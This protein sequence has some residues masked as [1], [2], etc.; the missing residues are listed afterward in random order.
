MDKLFAQQL[1]RATRADGEIDLAVLEELVVAAYAQ[2]ER[3]R[4]LIDRSTALMAEE[5]EQLNRGLERVVEERTAAL[6]DREA[7]LAGQNMLIDTAINNMPQGLV[8]FDADA[9]VVICNKRYL[10]MSG[11]RQD[12]VQPGQPLIELLRYRTAIGTFSGDPEQYIR[13]LLAAVARGETRTVEFE[14][15]GDRTIAVTNRPR[16]DGGW[17]ATHEDISERRRAEK[18]IA[19]MAHHDALTDLPNRLLLRERLA[20]TIAGIGKRKRAAV[21]C[22]DLDNFKTVNDTL[23]HQFGDGL[24]KY[25]A[26]RLRACVGPGVTVARVGG[27][28]FSLILPD[29]VHD[30]DCADLA[31]RVCEA[32]RTPI[33]LAG[34]PILI[35]SSI[36]IAL[37]PDHGVEPDELLKNADLALYRAKADGRGSYRFF[38]PSMDARLKARRALESELRQALIEG[39]FVLHYQPILNVENNAITCCEALVRWQHPE[40]GLIP[41]ADFIPVA[42]EIGL[43]VAL[44]EWVLRKACADAASWP[45]QIKVAVNLSPIQ[46]GSAN[47]VPTV[48][49][50]LAAAGLPACRLELEITESVMIQNTEATLAALHQLRHLGVK[51]SMDDFGTGYSA[52][53]YLRLFAFDKL[54]IDRCFINDLSNDASRAIVRAVTDMARS[55]GMIT[56][57]EGVETAEQFDHVR[58]LCCDE[59]QGYY[60]SRP[61]P[62]AMV[63]GV[64]AA[65]APL[66]A[67]S[68]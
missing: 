49:G 34:H 12:Q 64:I 8:M 58:L 30:A 10:E 32:V 11:L 5:L 9:R 51:I 50:A 36:G 63:H 6:R 65:Y 40:R 35:D 59:V 48:I 16:P 66:R 56:T 31:Q 44:G 23:G 20:D 27:D 37:A 15:A 67:K 2:A 24:L 7:R 33:E 61:Q 18:K 17:V 42:E 43:I 57:A 1:T 29:L 68:A 38:E 28:E 55:L 14:L 25:V 41:P 54:K 19:H 62:L 13:Q 4:R 47:L 52:L 60:I 39:Q 46:M 53:S 3:D 22:I 45:S 21:F 26:D